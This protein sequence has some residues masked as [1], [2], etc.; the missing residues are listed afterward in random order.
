MMQR[1]NG[2]PVHL[3]SKRDISQRDVRLIVL[4]KC[5]FIRKYFFNVKII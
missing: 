3:I 2:L 1:T 5:N 4:K